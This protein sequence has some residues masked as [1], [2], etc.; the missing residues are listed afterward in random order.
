M[1]SIDKSQFEQFYKEIKYLGGG[2]FG[3]VF[4]ENDLRN[5]RDVAIKFIQNDSKK[6]TDELI[7]DWE[8][9]SKQAIAFSHKNII[10]TI[11]SGAVKDKSGG[12]L[13]IVMEYAENGNLRNKIDELKSNN[14]FI[15]EV[16]LRKIFLEI[17]E[18]VKEIHK[19]SL[20]RD[21][22]PENILISSDGTLKITDFGL[23]KYIDDLTRTRT[24]KGSGTWPYMSPETWTNGKITKATDIY[25][26]GIT[27]Y[28][29]STL[30]L[31]YSSNDYNE[32]QSM[33]KFGIIPRAKVTNPE[34]SDQLDG[35]IKKM[36]AKSG[37]DCYTDIDE[38][39]MEINKDPNNK[40]PDPA[41]LSSIK[42]AKDIYDKEETARSVAQK[43]ADEFA[44]NMALSEL[45]IKNIIE[46]FGQVVDTFNSSVPENKLVLS[47]GS[48]T[49]Y[50]LIYGRRDF[51]D[52]NF[53][54]S[55]FRDNKC[56]ING[57]QILT[58]C[59]C[60][61]MA[62]KYQ[63]QGKNFVCIKHSDD[64][65]GSWQPLEIKF[66][67]LY[68]NPHNNPIYVDYDTLKKVI[69]EWIFTGSRFEGRLLSNTSEQINI[70]INDAFE[71]LSAQT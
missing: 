63:Y 51:I 66:G 62:P 9:E 61:I 20:H 21:I 50:T 32:I 7:T 39:I 10:K 35:I 43:Q 69:A 5:N 67:A 52:L 33:H 29:L 70:L 6:I 14:S 36:M 53:T 30:C 60:K 28:E 23:S 40:E 48:D 59:S 17:L 54:Q 56:K 1:K 15:K 38:I 13:Y 11:S 65:Y 31:P 25:S 47:K 19:T 58:F 4:L 22:K 71:A 41:L 44:Q 26:L 24:Y 3:K 42:F 45:N 49:S 57:K 8:R 34:I 37:L 2:G 55:V 64:E 68:Q 12:F 16:E 18:G 46:E 27:F